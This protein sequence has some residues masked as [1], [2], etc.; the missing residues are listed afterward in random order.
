MSRLS[1]NALLA[2]GMATIAAACATTSMTVS[3]HV[4][5]DLEVARYRTY[6]WG[7]ADALPTGDARLDQNPYFHDYMQGAVEKELAARG[8]RPSTSDAP[9]LLIHYHASV[10]TRIDVS[11]SEHEY[12]RCQ[13][14][15]CSSWIQDYEAGTLV[16]DVVDARTNRLIWRGWAQDTVEAFENR[17]R[18]ARKVAE[19][20]RRMMATFPRLGV[21]ARTAANGGQP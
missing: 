5:G 3:S 19:A 8:L 4:R 2:I 15:D 21:D 10:D 14:A 12:E 20:V 11:R 17:D 1:N 13:G 16:L 9:H 6:A 7:P 18:M